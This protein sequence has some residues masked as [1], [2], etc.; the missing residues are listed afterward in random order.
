MHCAKCKA[1]LELE[2]INNKKA[3]KNGD[4]YKHGYTFTT[5]NK[6]S[7]VVIIDANM[8]T[9]VTFAI[10]TSTNTIPVCKSCLKPGH[11]YPSSRQCGTNKYVLAALAAAAAAK[12][13]KKKTVEN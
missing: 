5:A 8:A 6:L 2:W 7:N 9:N 11:K 3:K 12:A 13:A 4:F 10:G 1:K